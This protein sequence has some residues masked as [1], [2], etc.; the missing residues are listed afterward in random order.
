M[1][2]EGQ[3]KA[4]YYPT[5]LEVAQ[6]IGSCLTLGGKAAH[7]LDPCCG[8]GT[9]LE[10]V[11]VGMKGHYRGITHG[12]ELESERAAEAAQQLDNV[13]VGDSLKARVRGRFSLLYLNP[14]YD[15]ADGKRLELTFL[16]HWQKALLPGGVLVYVVPERYLG[17]YEATLT[18]QFEN[19][20]VYRFPDDHYDTFKQVVVLGV[21]RSHTALPGRLPD[22]SGDLS[23]GCA[24]YTVPAATSAP[25]LHLDDQD[26]ELLVTEARTKGCWRRAW[27]LL[28]PPDP[29]TFRPLLPPRKGHVALMIASGLLNNIAIE[30]EGR[31]LLVRGRVRKDVYTY[32]EE[33]EKGTKVIERDVIKTEVTVLNLATAELI[34]VA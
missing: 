29:R 1:R 21:K 23:H 32:E 26:P 20:A 12:V 8:P 30:V 4:G 9:A 17:E 24:T 27:D 33:D 6:L 13:L 18:A 16:W 25:Q 2:L 28:S 10:T 7:L 3:S 22:V 11:N 14:P 34:E 19:L 5:P 31:K 15:Q